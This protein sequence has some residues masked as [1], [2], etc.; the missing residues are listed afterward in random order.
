M[1]TTVDIPD[2]MLADAMRYTKAKTKR[3]AI[4]TALEDL[5]RRHGQAELIQYFG[6][7]DSLM[8][9]EEIEALDQQDWTQWKPPV[10]PTR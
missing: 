4:L 3:E 9:N 10:P 7:F 8:T 5:N 2:R 6:T 1:K